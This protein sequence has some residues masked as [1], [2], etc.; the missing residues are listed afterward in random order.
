M[1]VKDMSVG[2]IIIVVEDMQVEADS[3]EIKTIDHDNQFSAT[4]ASTRVIGMQT[5]HTRT[6]LT[7]NSVLTMG[8]GITH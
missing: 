6:K 5:V 2:T 3:M 1:K 7:S 8:Y 4:H